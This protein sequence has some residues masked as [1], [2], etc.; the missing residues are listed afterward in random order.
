[1][2]SGE[3][4]SGEG[5]A[6]EFL[7]LEPYARFIE[8]KLG[9]RP[10]PGTLNLEVKPEEFREFRRNSSDWKMESKEYK[11]RKLGGI[12]VFPVGVQQTQ[13]GILEA[14][15]SRYSDSIIEV[16]AEQKL[17]DELGLSD[18]DTVEIKNA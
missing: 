2:F 1:M 18:G 3:V 13:A 10:F 8:R 5:S 9:F 17:R 4:V 11:G 15:K 7:S 6:S 12:E 14:E 16:V